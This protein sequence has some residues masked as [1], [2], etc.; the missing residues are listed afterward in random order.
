MKKRPTEFVVLLTV[1]IIGII[2][3]FYFRFDSMAQKRIIYGIISFYF[4]W[5]IYF[6]YKRGDLHPSI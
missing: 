2:L 1:F 4:F 5:S 6:H 3:F